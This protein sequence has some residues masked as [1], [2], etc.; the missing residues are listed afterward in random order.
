M[1]IHCHNVFSVLGGIIY[2]GKTGKGTFTIAT[3][4]LY[5]VELAEE[6]AEKR[7]EEENPDSVLYQLLSLLD[8]EDKKAIVQDRIEHIIRMYRQTFNNH[9]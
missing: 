3:C 7:M 4:N 9:R 2:T 5:R 1:A 8:D 6:R